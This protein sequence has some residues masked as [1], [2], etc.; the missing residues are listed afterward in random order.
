MLE[1]ESKL[2]LLVCSNATLITNIAENLFLNF[3]F[4]YGHQ[5][6][7]L[8]MKDQLLL[9]FRQDILEAINI[10]LT[11]DHVDKRMVVFKGKFKSF[12]DNIEEHIKSEVDVRMNEIF[13][14]SRDLFPRLQELSQRLRH[15][16]RNNRNYELEVNND[17]LESLM[18]FNTRKREFEKSIGDFKI[19]SEIHKYLQLQHALNMTHYEIFFKK[20]HLNITK[21]IFTKKR[22]LV[23]N[24]FLSIEKNASTSITTIA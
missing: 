14:I 3:I 19:I 7:G 22:K 15:Q 16:F 12:L 11:K 23:Q 6:E 1:N 2:I 13:D 24:Y 17:L 4:R 5:L 10:K 21:Y 18:E 9:E 8:E 20:V